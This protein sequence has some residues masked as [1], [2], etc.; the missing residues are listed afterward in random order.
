VQLVRRRGGHQRPAIQL[1]RLPP[2]APACP[3]CGNVDMQVPTCRRRST[4]CASR[5]LTASQPSASF[6]H[7]LVPLPGPTS[8]AS[9]ARCCT[10]TVRRRRCTI[11]R[12][13]GLRHWWRHPQPVPCHRSSLARCRDAFVWRSAARSGRLLL[14]VRHEFLCQHEGHNAYDTHRPGLPLII[15]PPQHRR[16]DASTALGR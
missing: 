16:W 12:T 5:H 4:S 6:P 2:G 9:R 11:T 8:R 10:A 7:G 15:A 3:R 1:V 14:T 13:S